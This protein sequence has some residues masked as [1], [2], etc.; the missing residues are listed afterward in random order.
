M[1]KELQSVVIT[2]ASGFV[3]KFLLDN[4]KDSYNLFG[5][6]R[7]SMGAANIPYHPNIHWMQWD[8]ANGESIDEVRSYIES[9]GGADYIIHLAAYY[10]FDYS[11]NPEY[12]RTNVGGTKNIL[13]LAE[14]L[15]VKRL[16]FSSSVAACD[17]PENNDQVTEKSLPDADYHYARTKKEGEKLVK[18]SSLIF[19]ASVVR[20]AAVYSDWCEYAPLYKF[21][22][23]W[24][25]KNIDSRILAGRG[26]S[27]IPYIH[28]YDI[29]AI[30]Q[31]II[32]ESSRLPRFAIFNASPDGS[33]S[34]KE[35]FEWTTRYF[36][37]KPVRPFHLPRLLA[38]PGLCFKHFLSFLH[39]TCD[40]PFEKFWMIKYIDK[41]LDTESSLTRKTLEWQPT[42]RFKIHRRLLFMLE[43]MKSHPNEWKLKNEAALKKTEFRVNYMIYEKMAAAQVELVDKISGEILSDININKFSLYHKMDQEDYH[44]YLSTLYHLLMATVRSGER[45]LMLKYIDDIAIKRFA[46]GFNAMQ[47]NDTLAVYQDI[48]YKYLTGIK[49][50]KKFEIE[51]HDYII[52][53]LQLAKDE[54]EDLYESLL[55]KMPAEKIAESPLLPDCTE[56]KRMIRQLSAFY[57]LTPESGEYYEDLR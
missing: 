40:E 33:T 52:L 15:K 9:N 26:E 5:I 18:E 14:A 39:L 25:S 4:L 35:L 38:Y 55:Q 31:K 53:S 34:H 27:A 24:T 41:K 20:F 43:K 10:D 21:I 46:E 12:D 13:A 23:N 3:G 1:N 32:K 11:D 17:F 6:A 48:I 49:E 50:L 51:V 57:Q 16:I 36:Y 7:R 42:E 8:I 29:C 45:S 47:I 44:C 54:I 22:S 28:V 37:G 2:G 56:L 30:I 19:P